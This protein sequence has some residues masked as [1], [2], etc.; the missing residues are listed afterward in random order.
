MNIG[1][2]YR[3]MKRIDFIGISV[4]KYMQFPPDTVG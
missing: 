2:T 1:E 4:H 3:G